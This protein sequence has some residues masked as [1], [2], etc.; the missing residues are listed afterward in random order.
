MIQQAQSIAHTA[1]GKT[2]QNASRIVIQVDILLV[3]HILKPRRDV[4]LADTPESKPLAPGKNRCR[5]LVQLR[6]RQNEQQMLRRFLDDLQQ[7][8][9]GG[10]RPCA[11][12]KPK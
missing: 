4:L 9:K 7:G 12:T 1:I 2:R 10:N 6:S 5:N 11:R 3:C 8:I